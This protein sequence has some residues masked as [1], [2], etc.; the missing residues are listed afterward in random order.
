MNCFTKTKIIN[1]L[2]P[3]FREI[4]HF[5]LKNSI[6]IIIIPFRFCANRFWLR[7]TKTL[8][9]CTSWLVPLVFEYFIVFT[10]RILHYYWSFQLSDI[11][12]VSWYH[13]IHNFLRITKQFVSDMYHD[14]YELLKYHEVF[15]LL[16]MNWGW[17]SQPT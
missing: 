6:L 1:T 11:L 7:F 8:Y 13:D 15:G 12:V 5:Y 9:S 3:I 10:I 14:I 4:S 17:R 16:K 2:F